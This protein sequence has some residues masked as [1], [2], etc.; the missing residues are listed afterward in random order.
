MA[1]ASVQ[2]ALLLPIIP[3]IWDRLQGS[4]YF[5]MCLYGIWNRKLLAITAKANKMAT[6]AT[7]LLF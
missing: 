7:H 3:P 6:S 4:S 5:F 2:V 1:K